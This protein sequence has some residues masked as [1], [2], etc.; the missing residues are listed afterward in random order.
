MR[1]LSSKA[2]SV[3]CSTGRKKISPETE[4]NISPHQITAAT[5]KR[6]IVW[7][8]NTVSINCIF[9]SSTRK[10]DRPLTLSEGWSENGLSLFVVCW[11]ALGQRGCSQRVEEVEECALYQA[12]PEQFLNVLCVI[13]NK[14][15][16]T[17]AF[18]TSYRPMKECKF[19]LSEENYSPN[20]AA[21]R[22]C[23]NYIGT[24]SQNGA[25]AWIED[26]SITPH[27]FTG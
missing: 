3:K 23:V 19:A 8:N 10:R 9:R 12:G 13:K 14:K 2:V 4:G 1:S 18:L 16:T 26:N 5:L 22:T 25:E 24:K 27:F 6:T 11:R 17:A 21:D 7:R 20:V 15:A